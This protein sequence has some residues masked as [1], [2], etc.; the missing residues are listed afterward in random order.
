M[1]LR[2]VCRKLKSKIYILDVDFTKDIGGAG[3]A[4]KDIIFGLANF[5]EVI[6][7]P[8]YAEIKNIRNDETR[9]AFSNF[10]NLLLNYGIPIPSLI[11]NTSFTSR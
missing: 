3:K 4:S 7:I 2:R 11:I 9:E 8:K 1:A 5:Y 6:F 10:T